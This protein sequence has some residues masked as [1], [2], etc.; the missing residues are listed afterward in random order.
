MDD[1]HFSNMIKKK[2]KKLPNHIG[3]NKIPKKLGH[4]LCIEN[5]IIKDLMNAFLN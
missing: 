1:H 4:V 3:E 2:K 5:K